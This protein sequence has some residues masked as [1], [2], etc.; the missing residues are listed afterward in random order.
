MAGRLSSEWLGGAPCLT[1]TKLRAIEVRFCPQWPALAKVLERE[2]AAAVLRRDPL[3]RGERVQHR[4]AVQAAQTGV[5]L[6]A[7][8]DDRLVVHGAVVHMEHARVDLLGE[9]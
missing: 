9:G 4:L 7:E 3:Q 5:L 6:A 1:P 2:P 8:G